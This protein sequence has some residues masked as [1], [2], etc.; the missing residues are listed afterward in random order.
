MEAETAR[1]P[2][3]T[4]AERMRMIS[5]AA[6]EKAQQESNLNLTELQEKIEATAIR[7]RQAIDEKLYRTGELGRYSVV[8]QYT[9]RISRSRNSD[10]T[11]NFIKNVADITSEL[12]IEALEA[13]GFGVS[14][15]TYEEMDPRD[16]INA[17]TEYYVTN[18]SINW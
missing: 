5:G 7:Q 12:I 10:E 11:V 9:E 17:P 18:F 13:D 1:E 16:S 6:I 8:H 2:S 15:K 4:N 14:A 3:R